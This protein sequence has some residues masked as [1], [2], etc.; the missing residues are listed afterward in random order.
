MNR[1]RTAS[2]D[3]YSLTMHGRSQRKKRTKDTA[4]QRKFNRLAGPVTVR[5]INDERRDPS[6]G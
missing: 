2:K 3:A 4:L 1:R 5:N 6:A